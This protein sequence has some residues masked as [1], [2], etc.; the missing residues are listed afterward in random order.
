MLKSQK[1]AAVNVLSDLYVTV[2]KRFLLQQE[3]GGYATVTNKTLYNSYLESHVAGKYTVGIFSR[4][5]LSKVIIF[6]VD[7]K[8]NAKEDALHLINVLV[9]NFSIDSEDIHVIYSGNKGYHVTLYFTDFIKVDVLNNFYCNVLAIAGFTKKQVELRPQHTLGVKLPL[10]I[11]KVTGNRCWF[12]DK[13]NFEEIK[14]FKYITDSITKIDSNNFISEQSVFN[15]ATFLED[16]GK[17]EIKE[18]EKAVNLSNDDKLYYLKVLDKIIQNRCLLSEGTRN[19]AT[20]FLSMY[21]KDIYRYSE[22]ETYNTIL[23]IMLNTKRNTNYI[24]STEDGIKS[25]TMSVVKNTYNKDYKIK[26]LR[27]DVYITKEEILYIL[28]IKDWNAK[29]LFFIHLVQSKRY[30]NSDS[31]YSLSYSQMKKMLVDKIKSDATISRHLQYLI[32]NNHIQQIDKGYFDVENETGIASTYQIC[33][34]FS[35]SEDK[36]LIEKNED[37]GVLEYTNDNIVEVT[38]E[39]LLVLSEDKFNLQINK[40]LQTRSQREKITKF[41]N[42]VI[43]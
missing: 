14:N 26:V 41:K 30:S 33:K 7:T 13:E 29:V 16:E 38:L 18:V 23:D 5:R 9:N 6:D 22:E 35:D 37:E 1:E 19:D 3:D 10:G 21:L 11:H 28:D 25:K 20:L 43:K 15:T 32:K 42:N 40:L 8:D 2:R 24:D 39:E 12:V 27:K 36:I 4:P 34:S 31:V 17:E